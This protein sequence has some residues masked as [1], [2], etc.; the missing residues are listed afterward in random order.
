[1]KK[2]FAV[3][4][5]L[6]ISLSLWAQ[7]EAPQEDPQETIQDDKKPPKK[8]GGPIKNRIFEVSLA[9]IDVNLSNNVITADKYINSADEIKQTG[10]FFKDSITINLNDFSEGFT[11][12]YGATIKPVSFKFNWQDKWGLGLDIGHINFTGNM[13]LSGN[14]LS[15]KEAED[16]KSGIG[17]AVFADFGIPAFFHLKKLKLKIRPSVFLPIF[18]TEPNITYNYKQLGD[19]GMKLQIDYDMRIYTAIDMQGTTDNMFDNIWENLGFDLSLGAEYPLFD[20]MD[21]GVDISNI[22][23]I[24]ANLEKYMQLKGEVYFDS[25]KINIDDLLDGGEIP[26]DVLGY[27]K[28]MEIKYFNS[29]STKVYRPFTVLSYAKYRPFKSPIFSLIPS[30]GF[31]INPLYTK[32]ASLEGGLSMSLDLSN[33]FITT[34]GVN[35]NDRKWKN[36]IDFI[37]NFRA[38]EIDFGISFQSSD[39]VKSFQGAG[40]GASAGLKLG[41]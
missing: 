25:S 21:I 30:F 3:F 15:L 10:K 19:S 41:W 9:N 11:Y 35:Y 32:L 6:F 22:P 1:M 16:D 2:I 29:G 28:D 24:T 13:L 40:F 17:A 34:I 31:S 7:E 4:I 27:P 36:S 33:I 14:M 12:N 39:F 26:E 5:I 8:K 20:W 18:Y 38:I 37:L 23:L